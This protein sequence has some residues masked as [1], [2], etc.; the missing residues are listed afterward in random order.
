MAAPVHP[1]LPVLFGM[2]AFIAWRM[3]ARMRRMIGRQRLS[4][5]RPTFTVV[6]FPILVALLSLVA[7]VRAQAALALF[8]GCAVGV[9]L[10]VWGLRL[11]RFEATPQGLFYTPNRYL[12]VSLSLLLIARLGWRYLQLLGTDMASASSPVA[13]GQ[14]PLTLLIF[15]MLAGYYT[16]YAAGLLR[17]K[18]RAQGSA[19]PTAEA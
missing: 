4:R 16:S 10:G 17:W 5:W 7:L 1:S 13:L 11:T 6:F 18:A 3:A 8:A 15:G 9:G 2:A 19:A 12:G 14:S